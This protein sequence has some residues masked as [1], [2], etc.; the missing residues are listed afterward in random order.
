MHAWGGGMWHGLQAGPGRGAPK[1]VPL[2]CVRR[3]APTHSLLPT[4]AHKGWRVL[5]SQGLV[6][7]TN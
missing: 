1:P 7:L 3:C 4:Q 2:V 6:A 5:P